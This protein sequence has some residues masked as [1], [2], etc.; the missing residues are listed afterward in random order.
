MRALG[1]AT[2]ATVL[3]AV[4]A[5][6]G[7]VHPVDL[8]HPRPVSAV[9]HH[10]EHAGLETVLYEFG[11]DSVT[12]LEYLGQLRGELSWV[13]WTDCPAVTHVG[14]FAVSG[15]TTAGVLTGFAPVAGAE[16]LVIMAGTND[17]RQGIP[18]SISSL[19]LGLIVQA[20]GLPADRVI[21]SAIPPSDTVPGAAL[22]YNA[23][24]SE[25]AAASGW[26]YVD[27]WPAVRTEAGAWTPDASYDGAHPTGAV[28]AVTGAILRDAIWSAV[29]PKSLVDVTPDAERVSSG[30]GS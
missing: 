11:G 30:S 10:I 24:A 17:T 27:P 19:Y 22:A 6:A 12:T 13:N 26:L 15:A 3:L 16:V 25:L 20:S 1:A 18:W 23:A 21:L 28:Q 29:H 4:W 2:A 9:V 7:A 14:G 8:R 5:T